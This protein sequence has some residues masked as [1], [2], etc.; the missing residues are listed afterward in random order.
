MKLI[1][2]IDGAEY[3]IKK[4]SEWEASE[5]IIDDK[6]AFWCFN[7]PNSQYQKV[8]LY[9]DGCNMFIYGDYGQFSFDSMTWLG[10]VYNLEYDNIGYQMEKL[11]YESK[12]SL[13]VFDDSDC[14]DDILEWFEEVI[15]NRYYD[16]ADDDVLDE[17]I[18]KSKEYLSDNS[19]LCDYEISNFCKEN[20]CS[21]IEELLTFTSGLLDHTDEFEWIAH[22][23]SVSSD[24]QEFD[25][26]CES[27]LWKA[28]KRINQRY[29]IC[30]YA[31]QVCGEKLSER[32]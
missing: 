15:E 22:L 8:C 19:Y 29:F 14:R 31:L 11:N 25:E 27:N 17:I 24:L 30:M 21:D 28:G 2:K 7:K 12:Q 32:S 4:F 9:R 16:I 13:Y 23:R 26:P 6:K 3:Y 5:Q 20:N 18:K 1:E 10:S